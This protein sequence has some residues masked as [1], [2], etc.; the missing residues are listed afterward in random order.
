[1]GLRTDGT[2]LGRIVTNNTPTAIL[3][4]PPPPDATNIIAMA[5]GSSHSIGLR[6]DRTVTGWGMSSAGQLSPPPFATNVL[7]IAAGGGDSLALVPDPFA[8]PIPPHIGRPP[9]SRVLIAGRDAVLNALPIGG[10]PLRCQWYKNSN[11]LSGRTNQWL[12]LTN[13][14]FPDAGNYQFVAMNDFASATS[15]VAVVT[16]VLPP[17]TLKSPGKNGTTFSF[18]LETFTG[19]TY[20]T[21]FANTPLG[22]WTE[23]ERRPGNGSLQVITDTNAPFQPRFYRLRAVYPP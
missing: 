17:L 1:M 18:T 14:Q 20:I 22:P 10:L 21:E 19:P 8:P 4:G 11:L 5:A 13:C 2:V 23:L 16:V 9:L 6:S 12:A 7:A 15:A 3:Y